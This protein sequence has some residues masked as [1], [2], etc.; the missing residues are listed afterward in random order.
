VREDVYFSVDVE[1][2]GPIPGP[3][4][5]VSFGVAIAGRRGVTFSPADPTAQ[6]FY[7][8]LRPISEDFVPEALAVSGLD[9]DRLVAEG[10]D[11]AAAMTELT[12][13]V[14]SVAGAGSPVVVAYPASFDWMFLYWYLIRFTGSSVFGFSGCLDIK[15]MY[16]VKA[17]VPWTGAVK[18]NMPR[19]L[20]SRRPHTHNALD[21]AVE[22]AELFANLMR[23]DGCGQP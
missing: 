3:Y 12:R 6:T 1:T 9:R 22:Q 13:W 14:R 18:R 15:T 5:M 2:D 11:P 4:S 7:R 10:A 8:E 16:A 19:A 21:D 17:G 20:L 23:W